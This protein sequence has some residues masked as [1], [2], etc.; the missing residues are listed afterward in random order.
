MAIS[1]DN[2]YNLLH[3]LLALNS[4]HLRLC[5]G[6]DEAGMDTS[7]STA[8]R[9]KDDDVDFDMEAFATVSHAVGLDTYFLTNFTQRLNIEQKKTLK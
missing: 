5:N 8:T 4:I 6:V 9:G 7:A 3:T 2:S 1:T